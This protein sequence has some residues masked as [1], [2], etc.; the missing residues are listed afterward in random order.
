MTKL[1]LT[2]T[3]TSFVITAGTTKIVNGIIENNTDRTKLSDNLSVGA[4]SIVLGM[5]VGDITRRY[6]DVKIDEIHAW[7]KKNVKKEF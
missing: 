7:Y 6:T 1:Q 3:L 4:A 5:M 2:K